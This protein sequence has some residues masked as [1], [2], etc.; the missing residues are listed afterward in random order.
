MS[1][2][3]P[4]PPPEKRRLAA[5]VFTDVV[6]YSA[7][8]Q[9][10]EASTISGVEADL[11]RMRKLCIEYGGEVLNS[12]GDGLML[13]FPSAVKAVSFA[14]KV[15]GEFAARKSS[16]PQALE[17]RIGVHL[18]DVISLEN[19]SVA[20]DGVNIA[21]RLEAKAPPG[22]SCMSQTVY[23]TVNGK[24]PMQASFVGPQN[25][26]NIAQ[27]IPVWHVRPESGAGA[28]DIRASKFAPPAPQRHAKRWLLSAL[29]VVL[30]VSVA[31]GGWLWSR[32]DASLTPPVAKA[33]P[34]LADSK[35]IAVLPFT[36]MSDNKDNA[37]FADGMQ[38]EL[39]TQLALLSEL[40]VVSRTSVMDYRDTKKNIRQIG[41]ELGVRT[42]VEGSVR[43]AGNSVRVAVQLIDTGSDKHL[44][45]K[46]Y[47]RELKDVFAIQSE[48]A[49]E[50]VRA[51]KVSLSPHDQARLAGSQ[52]KTL[53]PT[54]SCCATRNW[55][56]APKVP[57]CACIR[58]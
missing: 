38:E 23:D 48:L 13:C 32:R 17:H 10:D 24:V 47:D 14:L 15:Q 39:L 42:L 36:N 35:S 55:S 33:G 8:M 6:G 11:D 51:L 27:P 1:N 18:G 7:R 4:S 57:A 56:I 25:L 40:K 3:T 37:Y 52:L 20:G 29:S 31:A 34:A 44:W 5:V 53:P 49:T 16:A 45:A 43:R 41:T 22:G 46:S 12:M 26:K 21:S 2:L 30:V 28:T 50:I 54:T 19:G 58:P 9:R